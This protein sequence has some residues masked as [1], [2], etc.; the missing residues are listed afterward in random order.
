MFWHDN[1]KTEK[2]KSET[3]EMQYFSKVVKVLIQFADDGNL[4]MAHEMRSMMNVSLA[5]LEKENGYLSQVK[6]NEMSRFVGDIGSK[7]TAHNTM[8]GGIVFLVELLFDVSGDV[9]FN[10]IP[11]QCLRGTIHG[12]LLHFFR[13]VGIFN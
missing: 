11:F 10:I 9:F 4:G 3:N 13:H 7:I 6:V 8:P 5:A 12:V 1:M 2:I